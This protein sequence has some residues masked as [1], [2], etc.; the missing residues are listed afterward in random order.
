MYLGFINFV[1]Y[2]VNAEVMAPPKYNI[3]K[4]NNISFILYPN[5]YNNT[6]ENISTTFLAI[7]DNKINILYLFI[8]VTRIT[9]YYYAFFIKYDTIYF[10]VILYV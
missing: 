3:V 4:N 9:I 5:L 10:E 2:I 7:V 6:D 1:K 8:S